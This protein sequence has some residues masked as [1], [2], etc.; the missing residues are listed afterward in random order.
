MVG[1]IG[2]FKKSDFFNLLGNISKKIEQEILDKVKNYSGFYNVHI[3]TKK[4]Y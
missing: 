3:W 4:L 2:N 1:W